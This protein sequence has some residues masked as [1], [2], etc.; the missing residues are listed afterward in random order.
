MGVALMMVRMVWMVARLRRFVGGPAVTD[1]HIRQ[2]I[3]ELRRVLRVTRSLR[4][5][6]TA[7]E[8]GPAVLGIV[9]PILALPISMMTGLPPE[10]VRAIVAHELAHIR[11]HDYLLNLV[12]MVI[13]AVLF[14][15]PAVW[16]INRQ[17]RIEREACCD[18]MAARVLGQPLVLA[19]SLALWAERVALR[20]SAA[21]AF[22]GSGRH[23]PRLLLDR[24]LRIV[25]PGYRPQAP[26]SPLGSVGLFL[27]GIVAL[28]VLSCGT[29]AVVEMAA[30][31]LTPAQRME[32]IV[33]T[34]QQY[35]PPEIGGKGTVILSGTLRTSDG[36]PLSKKISFAI[37][38]YTRTSNGGGAYNDARA[39]G[40]PSFSMKVPTGKTWLFV[41]G[42]DE[43]A[44][45][46]VGPINGKASETI[47]GIELVFEKGSPLTIRVLDEKGQ[48]V[49][50]SAINASCKIEDR[51]LGSCSYVTD[52][53]GIAVMPI[54]GAIK[55]Y[56]FSVRKAG[57]QPFVQRGVSVRPDHS[58]TLNL[59]HAQPVRGV[60]LSP[61]DR[62][63]AGVEIR[64]Y[65][66]DKRFGD[67]SLSGQH[68]EVLATTDAEGHFVL[69]ELEDDAAYL[70]VA[71]SKEYGRKAFSLDAPFQKQLSVKFGPILTVSGFIRG[72]LDELAKENGQP[73]VS[74]T[75][76]PSLAVEK[77]HGWCNILGT[78]AVRTIDGQ[79]RF[80]IGDLLPG[81]ITIYAGKHVARTDVAESEPNR[82]VTIDLTQPAAQTPRRQVVLRFITPDSSPPP[83]GKVYV[84]VFTDNRDGRDILDKSIPLEG[85][86]ARFDAYVS[87]QLVYSP[88]GMLGYW[89]EEARRRVEAGDGPLEISVP[90]VPAGAIAGQVL[91]T[92]GTSAV[93]DASVSPN[94][95][96][97]SKTRGYSGSF[98]SGPVNV[99]D[100]GRFFITPLP[101]D[102][103]YK[104]LAMRGLT[105]QVSSPITLDATHPTTN[106]TLRFPSTITAEGQVLDPEG[107]PQGRWRFILEFFSAPEQP[108]HSWQ[109]TGTD[110]E[111]RFHFPDLSVG[112]GHYVLD[113]NPPRD[114]RS[115]RVPLP[116]DGKP[117][118]VRLQRGLVLEGQVLE[119]GTN[120]PVPGERVFLALAERNAGDSAYFHAEAKTDGEGRF[121][122]NTLDDRPYKIYTTDG[123]Q[124]SPGYQIA[125]PG[126][127]SHILHVTLR[128][129]SPLKPQ[130]KKEAAR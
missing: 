87:G 72:K 37:N 78:A 31:A 73:S 62:P 25:L 116:L 21:M 86:V 9:R 82:Q 79:Q 69:N 47:S 44:P 103:T 129:G 12:Q 77:F 100:K 81:K 108:L 13:E 105:M 20:P 94:G 16:W 40:T 45:A 88:R 17:I 99:D 63:I 98:G 38:A 75:L 112:V 122:F 3:D 106:I 80:T 42:C 85:G 90:V 101:L 68:G 23:G 76:V 107:R 39:Y 56:D 11:R 50:D 74:F 35:A 7:E 92:D 29:S 18:A 118:T 6:E 52:G 10:A 8:F 49:G 53:K 15:N 111:G 114:F 110:K 67:T 43:Y 1:D 89:F 83:R 70:M 57:F 126:Q 48:P 51:S 58:I 130:E 2:L 14:F 59:S 22:A 19:E 97:R 66:K 109:I 104:V 127:E 26:L 28:G 46:L 71:E 128:E 61:Q 124:S 125:T 84:N 115:L 30:K 117:V 121:R 5:V 4:I 32:R 91:N 96:W 41:G 54:S 113:F 55:Q 120:R 65:I 33:E 27:G 123:Q 34:Q 95:V 36:K 64:Q 93:A 119:V 60:V 24:V 102:G